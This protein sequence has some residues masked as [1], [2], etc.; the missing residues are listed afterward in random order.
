MGDLSKNFSRNEFACKCGCGFDTVDVQ[1][2]DIL[3]VV[4]QFAD[5]HSNDKIFVKINSGCRCLQHNG[6]VGGG[7]NS[8]HLIGRAAD[9]CVAPSKK[10]QVVVTPEQVFYFLDSKY[11]DTLGLG[12]YE[13]FVH[14]DSRK[15]KARWKA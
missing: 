2:I 9:N 3:E 5:S 13:S 15:N 14:V 8:K 10:D 4:W 11:P 6:H 12:L 1:L 7:E